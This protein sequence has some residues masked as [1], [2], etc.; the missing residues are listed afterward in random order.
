MVSFSQEEAG[1]IAK[2][3][4]HFCYVP[5]DPICKTLADLLMASGVVQGTTGMIS[6][7]NA[8]ALQMKIRQ[9]ESGS[10]IL[11][12][13]GS[14]KIGRSITLS[15][16]KADYI[17]ERWPDEKLVIFY[18]FKQELNI[19]KE[20][21]KDR[22][23]TDLAT[24]QSKGNRQSIALQIQSGREGIRLSDGE[25]LIFY[26]I[27]HSAVSYWQG[28]DRLTTKE[29]METNIYWLFSELNGKPGIDKEIYDV[30]MRKKNFTTAHF[31][32]LYKEKLNSKFR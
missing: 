24:F 28:R 32:K 16:A 29:R 3:N 8:A 10:I 11:D 23:T 2:L 7:E 13:E 31:K 1:F 26:S 6:A 4:E 30:V 27:S 12:P 14:E 21:L 15:T 17:Q 18:I 19:I 25:L 9:I 5:M 20:V 22:V